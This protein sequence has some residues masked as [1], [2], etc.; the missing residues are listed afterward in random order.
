MTLAPSTRLGPYE[1]LSPL[2]A[3]GMG[4]VYRAKDTRLGREVAIK[5]LPA[6]FASDTDRLQR[7]EQEARAASALN[8]ANILT[9]FELGTDDGR[10][11]LVT[12]LLDGRSLRDVLESGETIS[13]KRA[14]DWGAQIARGLAA[15]H[16]KGIVHRDLKPENLFLC[17]DGRVKILDFGLAKLTLGD[18]G[19][20]ASATTVAGGTASGVILGTAGYMAPEQVRGE[21]VDHRVDLFALGCVLYE[22]LGGRRAFRGESAI[23]TLNAIL[24]EQPTPLAELRGDLP[25]SL[26][27]LVERCLEKERASRFQSARDLAFDLES[28]TSG[29]TATAIRQTSLSR[30]RRRTV[31]LPIAAA[32]FAALGAALALW[33]RQTPEP[34]IP[35]L[36]FLTHSGSDQSPAVSPDGKTVVFSSRRDGRRRLWLKQLAT[37][38]E[39]PLTDG[40]DDSPRFSPDGSLVLFTRTEGSRDSLFRVP[41][42]GG[43]PRKLASDVL[44]GDW[45]PDGASIAWLR[46]EVRGE[47]TDT[48][49]STASAEGGEPRELVRFESQ[50]F[51]QPRFSP[52]GGTIAVAELTRLAG[53]P[54]AIYLVDVATRQVRPASPPSVGMLSSPAWLG[55]GRELLFARAESVVGQLS[56]SSARLFRYTLGDRAP[57][58]LFWSP[59]NPLV[60]DVL[61][62]GQV[63]FGARSARQNLREVPLSGAGEGASRWLTRGNST[64][65]QPV[66]SPDGEWV[67]FSSNRGASLDLWAVSTRSGTVRRLTDDEAEDWDPGFGA[68]GKLLWSSNRSGNFEIW[69]AEPD[70]GNPRQ[71]THDGIDA[72]NPTATPDGEWI[73]YVS[74]N[75][76]HTG[77]RKI[78]PDGTGET[79]ILTGAEALA[80]LSPDGR[81]VSY[82]V[83]W[84]V[85]RIYLRVSGIDGSSTPFEVDLG[86]RA[87]GNAGA[88]SRGRSRWLPDG[89]TIVYVGWNADGS[90]GLFAQEFSPDRDT[91]A[92]R[93]RLA[94]FDPELATESFGISPDGRHVAIAGWEQLFSLMIADGLEGVAPVRPRHE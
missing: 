83:E 71:L 12:E 17:A 92:T 84:G 27:R 80:E 59:I 32:C 36:R 91:S 23:E 52:D 78:H 24:K 10:P 88:G 18:E 39:V 25:S 47:T 68:D 14:L 74:T 43:A 5:V 6:A 38:S 20:L 28:A 4:E 37:G 57:R 67:L 49:L 87:G 58:A 33:L 89:R 73:V 54:C 42:V 16:D 55:D 56:S 90:Y 85:D 40:E 2:G 94:G 61:A 62:P 63:V 8:D 60:L 15:A 34:T 31:L 53:A 22:L 11:Y 26:S 50:L 46:W 93:R 44:S 64:D 35:T 65:R 9:V 70:G 75:P 41:T 21:R 79:A 81:H 76:K 77:L 3:G 51:R 13:I 69:T 19:T 48:V 45:S 30:A 7:F 29:S 72:E 1:I 66:Y 86:A 82:S